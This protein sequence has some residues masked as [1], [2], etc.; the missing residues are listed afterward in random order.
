MARKGT[1][2]GLTFWAGPRFWLGP[3]FRSCDEYHRRT[4]SI[5]VPYVGGLTYHRGKLCTD[6]LMLECMDVWYRSDLRHAR[7]IGRLY[8]MW[9]L[10][11]RA[12]GKK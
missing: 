10:G 3:I 9:D 6:C 11:Y 8:A 4:F 12:T 2:R 7:S 5:C 1:P